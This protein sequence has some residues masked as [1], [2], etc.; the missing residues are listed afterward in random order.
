[1]PLLPASDLG[2]KQSSPA[3]FDS[4][5]VCIRVMVAPPSDEPRKR[6]T[7]ELVE[8][9]CTVL[10]RPPTSVT[11]GETMTVMLLTTR[12]GSRQYRDPL[13][14]AGT[15]MNALPFLSIPWTIV[16]RPFPNDEKLKHLPSP[17][18]SRDDL[19]RPT[20]LTSS[21][22]YKPPGKAS[23]KPGTLYYSL[24]KT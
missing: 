3:P 11:S 18:R 24:T 6:V 21:P 10:I 5:L 20:L 2:V 4:I 8:K 19:P 22:T 15:S 12:V 16:L 13:L 23:K 17:L 1:M 7:F 14:F 9:A